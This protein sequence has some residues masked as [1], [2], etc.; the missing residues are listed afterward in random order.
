MVKAASLPTFTFEHYPDLLVTCAESDR[1]VKRSPVLVAEVL[2][3][4]TAA[5]DIG[6]KFATYRQLASLREYVLIDQE[7]IR[8]QVYRRLDE[9]WF[10]HSRRCRSP[11][12]STGMS[13]WMMLHKVSLSI[14]R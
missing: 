14:P 10:V 4:S 9:H 1:Y 11:G 12:K 8:I 6:E 13:L 3:A 7:R 2:S 5:F